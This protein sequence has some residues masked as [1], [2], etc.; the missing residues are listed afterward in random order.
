MAF[1]SK[2]LALALFLLVVQLDSALAQSSC[3]CTTILGSCSAQV[4]AQERWIDVTTDSPQ[5]ARVDFLVDGLPFVT[6][7]IDGQSR[8]DLPNPQSD[9][10]ILLQSCRICA[11]SAPAGR[12]GG[13]VSGTDT[14]DAEAGP[15]EPLIR[16][17]PEYPTQAQVNG[18]E[19][20]VTVEFEVNAQGEVENATV[21]ES[22]PGE[23]FNTAA[24]QAVRRWRYAA[25]PDRQGQRVSERIEF[26]L[27]D[28]ILQLEP[29]AAQNQAAFAE[30]FPRNQCIREDASY[31]FGEMVEADLINACAEPLLVF[32]CAEGV[33][34]HSGRWV[35][36]DSERLETLLAR[37]GDPR[38]GTTAQLGEQAANISWLTYRDSFFIARAPYSQYWWIACQPGD[39]VCRANAQM[40]VRSMDSQPASI[41]PRGR[42]SISVARSY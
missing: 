26:A 22:A 37:P 18:I 27:A 40:W 34:R 17:N 1:R 15:L 32:G 24:L 39:G 7:V 6:T 30:S 3:N 14:S 13:T 5:C 35:C 12:A 19:G 9:P 42:A 10:N 38:V 21:T 41:D 20:F 33:G 29:T 28:M 31:N 16:W 36:T 25:N 2:P 4:T 11:D 23:L 8:V